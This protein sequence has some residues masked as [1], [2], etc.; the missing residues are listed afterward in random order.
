MSRKSDTHPSI[1]H[2]WNIKNVFG[3]SSAQS[4]AHSA[5]QSPIGSAIASLRRVFWVVAGLSGVSNLLMLT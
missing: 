5:S 3:K 2:L 1:K 4:T